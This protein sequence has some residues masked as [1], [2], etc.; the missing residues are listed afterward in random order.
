[1]LFEKIYAENKDTLYL[2]NSKI[3]KNW[4][5]IMQSLIHYYAILYNFCKNG[6]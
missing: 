1:M 3:L 6:I 4:K 2:K 5:I